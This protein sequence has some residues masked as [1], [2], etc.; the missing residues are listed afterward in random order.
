MCH[1]ATNSHDE[2]T[3]LS[4]SVRIAM[5]PLYLGVFQLLIELETLRISE[6]VSVQLFLLTVCHGLNCGTCQRV[7]EAH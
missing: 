6:G 7:R 1:P 3:V 5:E 4:Q 2:Q